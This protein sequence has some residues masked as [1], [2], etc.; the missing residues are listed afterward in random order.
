MSAR[1]FVDDDE[2][3]KVWNAN[4]SDFTGDNTVTNDIYSLRLRCTGKGFVGMVRYLGPTK[5]RF[6]P[7]YEKNPSGRFR[8]TGVQVKRGGHVGKSTWEIIT[9]NDIITASS[10]ANRSAEYHAQN[11]FA[12]AKE[13]EVAAIDFAFNHAMSNEIEWGDIPSCWWTQ[14]TWH[15]DPLIERNTSAQNGSAEDE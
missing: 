3:L 2:I 8:P 9:P 10:W 5:T 13:A 4:P 7:E 11:C 6:T 1:D 14:G 12:T 15:H